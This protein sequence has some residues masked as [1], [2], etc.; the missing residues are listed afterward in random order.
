MLW[1]IEI[2]LYAGVM[3]EGHRHDT[4]SGVLQGSV[5][6][7]LLANVYLHY[8]LGQWFE[9]DVKPR[10]RGEAYIIRCADDFICA[11]ELEQDARRF[12][13]VLSKRLGRYSL[14]L[15]E[16]KTKLLRFGRFAHR[17][18]TRLSEGAPGTFDFLGFT[19]YCGTS[20]AGKFKLKRKTPTKKLRMKFQAL[21]DW[22]R[23][24]LTEPTAE[25]WQTLQA[26]LIGHY[27]HYNIN[28]N[29]R[30]IMKYREAA[31]RM[32][33]RWLRRRSQ[34]S[35]VTWESYN[36]YQRAHP[37]PN[38][39]RIVDLIAMARRICDNGKRSS[40]TQWLF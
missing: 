3:I 34:N 38:P 20:R 1:L 27:Q 15:A 6:S 13:E 12:Q 33:L 18:S 8:V 22:F 32:R 35:Q 36:N 4:D 9:H 10:L 28:D 40:Q 29:W 30:W 31:R 24:M 17:D 25:V 16:N 21:K 26:K 23:S 19:H 39:D 14:E 2:F 5:L 37:L 7:P 11:F